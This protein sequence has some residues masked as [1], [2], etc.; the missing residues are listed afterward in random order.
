ME[1]VTQRHPQ[2]AAT[3]TKSEAGNRFPAA[4]EPPEGDSRGAAIKLRLRAR[5]TTATRLW[6]SNLRI[7]TVVVNS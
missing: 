6:E 2:D 4:G 1:K 7:I 3:D 5:L